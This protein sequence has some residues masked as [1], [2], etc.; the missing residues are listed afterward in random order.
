MLLVVALGLCW[1]AGLLFVGRIRLCGQGRNAASSPSPAPAHVSVIIPAR[2][3]AHRLPRLLASLARCAQNR[4]EVLVVDDASTDDT[5]KVA[6]AAGARV[7]QAPPLPPGWRG[8][9]WACHHGANAASGNLLLFLDADTWFEPDGWNTLLSEWAREPA[10]ALSILPFHWTRKPYEQLSAF[11]HLLMGAG[12]GAFQWGR[13]RP[14]GLF[15]PC[16]LIE[17]DVYEAVGGHEAVRRC[18]LEHLVLGRRLAAAG[19]PCRAVAGRGCLATRMYPDGISDLCSGWSKAFLS[20]TR[21]APTALLCGLFCWLTGAAG[22]ALFLLFTW[23]WPAAGIR[24]A[25]VAL[26]TAYAV[27][28]GCF[29]RRLGQ[30]HWLTALLYPAPLLFFFVLN[31][32]AALRSWRGRPATWK[33]RPIQ[34]A[35]EEESPC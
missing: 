24:L 28:I 31:A 25:A 4:R 34:E 19:I 16:L 32:H 8:K 33:N 18:V 11:F 14:H 27:Q 22:T 5:A 23:P 1:L 26:Y 29:L 30:Y 35:R 7:L 2:N 21:G 10:G 15:G 3:E 17:R 12:T 13:S 9:A 6:A 20:G